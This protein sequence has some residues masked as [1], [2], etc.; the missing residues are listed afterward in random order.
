MAGHPL[1]SAT[2]RRLGGP[3]P[4]QP[5]NQTRVHLIPPE[6][7]TPGH[8]TLCAY[9]VLAVVSNCYPPVWGRLPTRYSPVR[10]SVTKSSF[11]RNQIKCFVRLACVKHAASVHP[12]P[13][14]NSHVK[15]F[16][17]PVINWLNQMFIWF[18]VLR[19]F[20]YRNVRVLLFTTPWNSLNLSRLFHCSV[21]KVLCFVVVLGDSLF[22]LSYQVCFV[23]NFFILSK[24]FPF[25]QLVYIN[26]FLS[27]C[28]ELFELIIQASGEGGIWTLAPLLTTCTLSRGVPST[29]W[30]LLQIVD[31]N[32]L[33]NYRRH[34]C[35]AERVG[36]EP[37][38]PFGQ[39]V[40][41]TASLWPLRYL[42]ECVS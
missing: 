7:F 6:F 26:S 34:E 19:L 11:R 1:R 24:V 25:E 32:N 29:S 21:I 17:C 16:S 15:K 33:Y 30:V 22:I 2:D 31:S 9:A 39:T 40:F 37:T 18:T 36:F 20:L 35:L 23:K 5:A 4:R 41:K 38:R 10:H 27:L 28:Q 42:S 13:G 3:L 12:E 14:S 8:A